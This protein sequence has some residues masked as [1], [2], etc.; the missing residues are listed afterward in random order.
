MQEFFHG[1]HD[2]IRVAQITSV[3]QVTGLK[4]VR[5]RGGLGLGNI[6]L[7]SQC[8]R[9]WGL[10]DFGGVCKG[11]PYFEKNPDKPHFT[12][13]TK[14][15]LDPYACAAASRIASVKRV[16]ELQGF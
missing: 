7:E 1:L 9:V 2:H 11:T 8:F 4:A 15:C 3:Q 13:Q 6:P 10:Y 14:P 12:I 16:R 5:G